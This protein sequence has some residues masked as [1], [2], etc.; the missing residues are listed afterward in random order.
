MPRFRCA[1]YISDTQKLYGKDSLEAI[2]SHFTVSLLAGMAS[3]ILFNNFAKADNNKSMCTEYPSP[4][5]GGC[6]NILHK[7][8][9]C[10]ITTEHVYNRSSSIL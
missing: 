3:L 6:S 7:F 8:S 2:F 9:V 10:H 5:T 4:L 1:N